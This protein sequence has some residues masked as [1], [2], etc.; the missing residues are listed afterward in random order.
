V[1][2]LKAGRGGKTKH[3]NR[4]KRWERVGMD[5]NDE[6]RNRGKQ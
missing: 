5:G 2:R 4:W 3:R 1:I 6:H